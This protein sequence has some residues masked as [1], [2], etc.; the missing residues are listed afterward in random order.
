M[1]GNGLKSVKQIP[2]NTLCPGGRQTCPH[3]ETCCPR[4]YEQ[5]GCCPL[6]G[7]SITSDTLKLE[8]AIPT[9]KSVA[10]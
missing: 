7:V 10:L 2:V 1:A 8:S 3:D 5:W 6:P 9:S 4:G